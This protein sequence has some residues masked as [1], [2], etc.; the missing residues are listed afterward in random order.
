MTLRWSVDPDQLLQ[1]LDSRG[2]FRNVV[3]ADAYRD[4]LTGFVQ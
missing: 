2:A 1:A 3:N 4:Q